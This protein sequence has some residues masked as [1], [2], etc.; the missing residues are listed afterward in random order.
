M[1]EMVVLYIHTIYNCIHYISN[2]FK[3]KLEKDWRIIFENN[4][5]RIYIKTKQLVTFKHFL[6]NKIGK[7]NSSKRINRRKKNGL[8]K[9]EKRN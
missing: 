5:E 8:K 3:R 7:I 2:I 9:I 1:I 6:K 4:L